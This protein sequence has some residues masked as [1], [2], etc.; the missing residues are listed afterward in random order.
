[1]DNIKLGDF[2]LT[3][4]TTLTLKRVVNFLSPTAL[5]LDYMTIVEPSSVEW[6]VPINYTPL[7]HDY[8]TDK[9][10]YSYQIV[11]SPRWESLPKHRWGVPR[12]VHSSKYFVGDILEITYKGVPKPALVMVTQPNCG[13]ELGGELKTDQS[14]RHIITTKRVSLGNRP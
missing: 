12:D 3:G 2:V 8:D 7:L 1:M 5:L 14:G 6:V 13:F 10:L 4:T 11:D 9:L